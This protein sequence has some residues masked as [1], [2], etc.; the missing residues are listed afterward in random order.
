MANTLILP[1]SQIASKR[2]ITNGTIDTFFARY[3]SFQYDKQQSPVAEFARL[4][5][6]KPSWNQLPTCKSY[7]KA[8][9]AFMKLFD[10]TT[11]TS[12][13]R[14]WAFFCKYSE[15]DYHYNSKTDIQ[16]EFERLAALRKWPVGGK[17]YHQQ[18]ILLRRA[19][20]GEVHQPPQPT[21]AWQQV[22][23]SPGLPTSAINPSQQQSALNDDSLAHHTDTPLESTPSPGSSPGPLILTP[24]DADSPL[25]EYFSKYA[26][27]QY[28]S[29]SPSRTEFHRLVQHRGWKAGSKRFRKARAGFMRATG[30]EVMWYLESGGQMMFPIGSIDED[31]ADGNVPPEDD[32]YNN[33]VWKRVC[34]LL[35]LR[36]PGGL[37]PRSK[38]QCKKVCGYNIEAATSFKEGGDNRTSFR[39]SHTCTSTFLTL[40][41]TFMHSPDESH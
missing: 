25:A 19:L 40:L 31:S 33:A 17:L 30:D 18:Q 24:P 7:R 9:S 6:T 41:T 38:T 2:A 4:R 28:N 10:A 34:Q 29:A 8:R 5:A 1:V 23:A 14:A 13:D 15:F 37:T 35:E 20:S 36:T 12:A 21:S 39:C 16:S 22:A 11:A 3:H 26:N 27:F 32:K